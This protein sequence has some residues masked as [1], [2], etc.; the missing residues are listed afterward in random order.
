MPELSGGLGI[1][2]TNLMEKRIQKQFRN[3]VLIGAA[4]VILSMITLHNIYYHIGSSTINWI[5]LYVQFVTLIT[6]IEYYLKTKKFKKL[7]HGTRR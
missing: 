6:S 3:W 5:L 4:C 2:T 7:Y 1:N